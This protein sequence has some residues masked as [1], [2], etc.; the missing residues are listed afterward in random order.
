MRS[1]SQRRHRRSSVK[2]QI[3][4][5]EQAL[6]QA[7][8]LLHQDDLTPL[9]NRRGFRRACDQR[10]GDVKDAPACCVM[11]DLDGFKAINDRHGHP[12]GD[13]ALI[14]FAATLRRHMRPS[15]T[16]ARLGGDEF[17]LILSNCSGS[18]ARTMLERL[19]DALAAAP[20]PASGSTVFLRF[21]AGIAERHADESLAQALERADAAL[22]DAKRQGKAM[23]SLDVPPA[24]SVDGATANACGLQIASACAPTGAEARESD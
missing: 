2:Q 12:V 16:I 9:L 14:H 24:R 20:L 11:V 7:Q 5:L 15:D 17:A 4:A 22:L 10:A 23:V 1:N 19:R 6:Q 13:A 3:V 8:H 21:S 18:D